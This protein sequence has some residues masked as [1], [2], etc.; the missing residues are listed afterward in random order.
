MRRQRGKNE[1]TLLIPFWDWKGTEG[2]ACRAGPGMAP[3]V[4]EPGCRPIESC[5]TPTGWPQY[6]QIASQT[7]TMST[8]WLC[9]PLDLGGG[10][11][12]PTTATGRLSP[13]KSG[14][15]LTHPTKLTLVHPWTQRFQR[16]TGRTR[17]WN[18]GYICCCRRTHRWVEGL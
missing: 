9:I 11:R 17:K 12:P 7:G 4:A 16:Y 5:P 3:L 2:A 6:V 14:W 8:T 13:H 10:L 1:Q 18:P 15:V